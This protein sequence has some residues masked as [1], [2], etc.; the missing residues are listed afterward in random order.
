MNV[1]ADVEEIETT[2]AEKL[3]AVVLAVFLLVGAL[4]FYTR[5][6]DW[7]RSAATYAPTTA[8]QA[9]IDAADRAR[10][11]SFTAD[12][13]VAAERQKLELAR[14]AYR[15]ALEAHQPAQ[16][17]RR[18]YDAAQVRLAAAQAAQAAAH[19][20]LQRVQPAANRASAAVSARAS[21]GSR[22]HDLFAALGRLGLVL[23]WL[24]A[25]LW[26][27]LRLHRRRSR[28][29]PVA[30]AVLA[31]GAVLVLVFAGDYIGDYISW[32]RTGPLLLSVAGVA[33]S[34]LVFALLQRYVR[35]LTPVRRVRQRR[36]P[37]CGY[38]A[39]GNEHCEGCGR[40]VVAECTTCGEPR[41]VGTR[42]CGACGAT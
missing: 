37:F 36:C 13:R 32:P 34:L 31:A 15:T 40:T 6:D 1:R 2:R 33:A 26:L 27:L 4:W 10:G 16:Q 9:A 25:G 38:P 35:R 29:E 19:Q 20:Q 28:Y 30:Y 22:H 5:I 23:A 21:R 41:R 18:Q 39:G 8:E 7:T 3:L 24:A 12:R 14:E 11:A 42:F 17:L